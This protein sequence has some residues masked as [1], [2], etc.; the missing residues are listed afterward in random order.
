MILIH[1]S[2]IPIDCTHRKGGYWD[3]FSELYD[4]PEGQTVTDSTDRRGLRNPTLRLP[5]LPSLAALRC[6]LR[7]VTYTTVRRGSS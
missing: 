1:F 5:H 6:H 7:I 3:Y 4:E 2:T